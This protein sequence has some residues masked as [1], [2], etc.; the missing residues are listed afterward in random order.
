VITLYT[1]VRSNHSLQSKYAKVIVPPVMAA[2]KGRRD[3]ADLNLCGCW[4]IR[5]CLLAAG[6]KLPS[7][8][9]IRDLQAAYIR[10]FDNESVRVAA[11]Q[12]LEL[13]MPRTPKH[14]DSIRLGTAEGALS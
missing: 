2:L 7:D 11:E 14:E 13:L 1:V 3:F 10:H 6:T 5:E 8:E 4:V 12:A 9:L